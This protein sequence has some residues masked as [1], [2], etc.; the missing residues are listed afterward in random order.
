[1]TGLDWID[2]ALLV[3]LLSHAFRGWRVGALTSVFGLGGLLLGATVGLWLTPRLLAR[4]DEDLQ[5]P[6]PLLIVGVLLGALLGESLLI[7]VGLQ[8]RARASGQSARLLDSGIGAL[9]SMLMVSITFTLV[10]GAIRPI[11]PRSLT[12][13][14][15][16]SRVL[17]GME[18]VTPDA[19]G[20]WAGRFTQSLGEA[21]FPRVFSG[22]APEPVLPVPSPDTAAA[23]TAAVRRAAGSIVKINA[24]AQSCSQAHS[25]SGWVVAGNRVVTNA[26]VVAGSSSTTV[27][28]GGVGERLS[29]TVV[30]FNPDLDLAILDVPS[31]RAAAL[32][33]AGS[34]SSRQDAVVA[35]FPQGGGYT[36]KAAR[37]R[38]TVSANGDDI[39][40]GKGVV[41]QVY[42]LSGTVQPGNSGGPLLTTDGRV[43]GTIFARS[44]VD[45]STGYALTD[46]ATD[47]MLDKAASYRTPVS[48]QSCAKA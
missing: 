5:Q 24:D 9:V 31:L 46:A 40:G 16:D 39:Y 47:A 26:H 48:T 38:G 3:L 35:G 27:Q 2:L 7:R 10:G 20:R 43:A 4:W 17:A 23:K 25:G 28:V 37:V 19:A 6:F 22:L 18:K 44:M 12:T 30:A 42:S 45:H 15:N 1:M 34:L 41:R 21:G 29:A 13:Q 33:R 36:V 8:L 14:M 11:L 32:P